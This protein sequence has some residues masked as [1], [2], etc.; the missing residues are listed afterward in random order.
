MCET[1]GVNNDLVGALHHVELWVPSLK[2][3]E[4]EWGWILTRLGYSSDQNWVQGTSWRRGATYIVVEESP[5]LTSKDHQRTAP[6]LNHLA[7]HAGSTQQVDALLKDS[8]LHGWRPLFAE[9]Y[10]N[11]GGPDHYAAYLVNSDGFEVELIANT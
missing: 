1:G 7:F 10:P 9:K 4:D 5:A 6:G 3:A 11:A 8:R 2:R